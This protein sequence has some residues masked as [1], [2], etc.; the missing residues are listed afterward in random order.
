MFLI[1]IIGPFR[2][3][4]SWIM[5]CNIRKAEETALELWKRHF[6]VICPHTNTR[7]FQ[8]VLP[9]VDFLDGDKEILKRCNAALCIDGWR[10]SV[11]CISEVIYAKS[12][13]VRCFVDIDELDD[14]FRM[15]PKLKKYRMA[16]NEYE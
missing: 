2:A 15:K 5:E 12:M 3:S 1:Y 14:F 9:D 8:G 7:F 6:A 16:W 10:K 11:G 13:N 4:N